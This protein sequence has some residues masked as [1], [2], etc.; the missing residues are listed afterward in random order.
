MNNKVK[1][2]YSLP[3]LPQYSLPFLHVSAPLHQLLFPEV[4]QQTW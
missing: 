4:S 3:F 2:Q 1:P